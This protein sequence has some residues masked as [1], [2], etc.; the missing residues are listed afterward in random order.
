MS[1]ISEYLLE[2]IEE[3]GRRLGG[4]GFASVFL[5]KWRSCNVAIKRLHP[6]F[7]GLDSKNLP[8]KEFVDFMAEFRT[9]RKLAHPSIAQ[10]FGIVKPSTPAES[11]GVVMEVL[12]MSLKE[13]YAKMPPLTVGD[14]ISIVVCVSSAVEYL[15]DQGI[16]HRDITTS[17]VMVTD[18]ESSA[19]ARGTRSFAKIVDLGV[20]RILD[21]A[22]LQELSLSLTPG[23]DRYMA[24]E[25]LEET[26]KGKARYGKPADVFS[27]GVTVMS[28]LNK[29]EPPSMWILANHG[30]A[31]DLDSIDKSHP[32]CGVVNQCVSVKP[33]ARPTANELC[34]T[35]VGIHERHSASTAVSSASL[36]AVS[37]R[38]VA[39]DTE[40]LAVL[41]EELR[42]VTIECE[43]AIVQQDRISAEC[44]LIRTEAKAERERLIA[45]RDNAIAERELIRA[46][47]GAERGCLIAE[48]DNAI[49]ERNVT[50]AERDRIS[51]DLD[52]FRNEAA[53]ER[54]SLLADAHQRH[55]QQ[56]TASDELMRLHWKLAAERQSRMRIDPSL[57]KVMEDSQI[58]SPRGFFIKD[59]GTKARCQRV[60]AEDGVIPH[61]DQIPKVCIVVEI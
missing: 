18:T 17:N 38:G 34:A 59:T 8:T 20:A 29:R 45:E 33:E 13:R 53:M 24:P 28:M 44:E 39:S 2:G 6:A 58:S 25:T 50:V 31:V 11:Y 47:A 55:Y 57:R 10:V 35:A 56:A 32:L 52:V 4:G 60:F 48:C 15:H 42:R 54:E 22:K 19:S 5:A 7:M 21:D 9:L 23:A 46:E 16:L 3:T 12:A 26:S 1:T 30:R 14:E 51:A 27:V 49:A 36:A 40:E 61:M 41:R 43:N 37:D